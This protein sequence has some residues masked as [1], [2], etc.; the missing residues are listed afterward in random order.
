MELE[1][2]LGRM[3]ISIQRNKTDVDWK[4][5][6]LGHLF[7]QAQGGLDQTRLNIPC[8][9]MAAIIEICSSRYVELS[10]GRSVECAQRNPG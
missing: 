5:S 4:R 1:N 3:D 7:D 6:V 10:G 8:V 9:C 2:S